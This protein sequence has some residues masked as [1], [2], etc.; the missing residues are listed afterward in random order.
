MSHCWNFTNDYAAQDFPLLPRNCCAHFWVSTENNLLRQKSIHICNVVLC[1]KWFLWQLWCLIFWHQQK[2]SILIFQLQ[3]R[4]VWCN[5][6]ENEWH[7]TSVFVLF[8]FCLK[9]SGNIGCHQ[10]AEC[11]MKGMV[12]TGLVGGFQLEQ[13]SSEVLASSWNPIMTHHT[14]QQRDSMHDISLFKTTDKQ[15]DTR[16]LSFCSP[17]WSDSWVDLAMVTGLFI[18]WKKIK[19]CASSAIVPYSA[20]H[21]SSS[22]IDQT[23]KTTFWNGRYHSCGRCG[24]TPAKL[25]ATEARR[26]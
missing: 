19:T 3:Q 14:T 1:H 2:G 18:S 13:L 23:Q 20:C 22:D 5:W 24:P 21:E 4:M 16:Q 25:Q 7:C 8:F 6:F 15:C 26:I 11:L 10:R 12:A 17:V 9:T